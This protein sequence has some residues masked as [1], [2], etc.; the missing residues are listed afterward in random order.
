[1]DVF[2]VMPGLFDIGSYYLEIIMDE[3][4]ITEILFLI[5]YLL[6]K[7]TFCFPIPEYICCRVSM[8][9]DCI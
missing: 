8:R 5:I 2:F 3:S 7:T 4:F 1:M 6:F 9:L